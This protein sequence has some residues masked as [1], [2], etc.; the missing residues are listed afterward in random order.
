MILI[1]LLLIIR[2]VNLTCRSC[3]SLLQAS[4]GKAEY[5]KISIVVNK[6][7]L[8]K[9]LKTWRDPLARMVKRPGFSVTAT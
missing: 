5:W 8:Q 7:L 6:Y 4:A 2:V 1:M 9:Y 3:V